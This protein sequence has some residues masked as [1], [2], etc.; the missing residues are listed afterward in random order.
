MS[1][2][3]AIP[4]ITGVI[5]SEGTLTGILTTLPG[6]LAGSISR[7]LDHNDYQGVYEITPRVE[8]QTINTMD[9]IM[10]ADVTVN[11]IPYSE[12]TNPSGGKTI[13]IAYL[14]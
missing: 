6:A 13:N 11:E 3:V 7:E 14:E 5:S 9:K 12:T 4:S 1:E 8:A 2:I 10:R